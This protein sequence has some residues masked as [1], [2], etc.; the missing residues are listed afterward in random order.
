VSSERTLR[1]KAFAANVAVEGTVLGS[2][3]LRVVV[4]E[5]LLQ[6]GQLNE[7]APALGEVA[8][9]RTLSCNNDT[10]SVNF[11]CSRPAVLHS[12]QPLKK[13]KKKKKR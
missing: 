2:L 5:V 9:V 8:L 13:K 10:T 11:G 12:S 6:V 1:G 7:G 3:D 4:A